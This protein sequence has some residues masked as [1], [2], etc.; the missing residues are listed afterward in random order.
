M[1][2]RTFLKSTAGAS[3]LWFA[4]PMYWASKAW[5]EDDDVWDQLDLGVA[6]GDPRIDSIFVWTRIPSWGRRGM[7][8]GSV[9]VFVDVASDPSFA[10]PT[11]IQQKEVIT[12]HTRDYTVKTRID[13]L[14]PYTTYYYRFRTD[15][16]YLSEIGRTKT[17]PIDW[18]SDQPL[19]F[20]A[21]SCQDY[22]TGFYS[23]Y[24]AIAREDLDV[25]VHL[26]DFIYETGAAHWQKGQVRTDNIGGGVAK[27]LDEY[28]KKYRL[29]LT[30]PYLREARRKFPWIH[31]WDDHEVYNDY[32]G[33]DD[34]NVARVLAGY[35]AFQ[36][37]MPVDAELALH[38]TTGLP[39]F[40]MFRKISY[41]PLADFFAMDQRQYRDKSPC[42][43]VYG[44]RC[45]ERQLPE[46]SM[47][48][49]QQYAWL[50][51]SLGASQ[52][53][54]RF[55]LNEVMMMPFHI[56]NDGSD[57]SRKLGQYISSLDQERDVYLSL[58]SWDGFPA[59]RQRLANFIKNQNIKNVVACTGDIH[60][61]YTGS[62]HV[63]PDDSTSEAALVEVV[64]ASI[65][66]NGAGDIG[67]RI[68]DNIGP[69]FVRRQNPHMRFVELAHHGYA[70]FEVRRDYTVVTYRA[71]ESVK[72]Q[73]T[74]CFDLKTLVITDGRSEVM[75]S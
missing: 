67:S 60:N 31:I 11:I 49:A 8:T 63:D 2:R 42:Q 20:A 18:V 75:T 6:S 28:R 17:A 58:D 21:I 37:Y 33:V 44:S 64:T 3:L 65:S 19:K 10:T 22:T 9:P 55:L 36:E 29:Y 53:R 59:E 14:E 1:D 25:V 73:T 46:R 52:A 30:D 12:D 50:T 41:G 32:A 54:W 35:Q 16:G 38:A 68:V 72:S 23:V 7:T 4:T 70:R 74:R 56:I 57:E 15:D 34:T 13:G 62:V 45:E 51:H 27:N 39:Q 47:L 48:G 40:S 71:V 26:G 66:S 5:A 24:D 69:W 61:F 43:R